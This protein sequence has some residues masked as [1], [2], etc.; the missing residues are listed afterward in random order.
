VLAE[1]AAIKS[2]AFKSLYEEYGAPVLSQ[3]MAYHSRHEGISRVRKIE[4]C[5]K[6]FL[7]IEPDRRQLDGLCRRY[8]EAVK[9]AVID[10]PWVEGA[11]PLLQAVSDR[12]DCFIVS[13]T[14]GNE[15]KDIVKARNM[16]S[17]F[18]GVYG[19]PRLKEDIVSDVLKRFHYDVNACVFIGDA[20]TDYDAAK[21]LNMNFIGRVF[22]GKKSPFPEGT[23]TITDLHGLCDEIIRNEQGLS[24]D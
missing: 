1:S 11:K 13:G 16:G 14:P 3:A 7:G 19:S 20:M 23:R 6:H 2:D 15:L 4:Y 24:N 8:S 21:I 17:F 18:K 12:I 9:K 10:C 22:P 5:H